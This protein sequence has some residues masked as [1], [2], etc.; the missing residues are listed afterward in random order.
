MLSCHYKQHYRRY[1]SVVFH[2]TEPSIKNVFPSHHIS[3]RDPHPRTFIYLN[4]SWLSKCSIKGY[5][6]IL[7]KIT[8]KKKCNKYYIR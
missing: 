6:G 1:R 3:D 7:L 4:T 5:F 2:M 8:S